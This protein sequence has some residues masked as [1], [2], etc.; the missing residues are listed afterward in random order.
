[1][2]PLAKML[3]PKPGKLPW[4]PRQSLH[5]LAA[6]RPRRPLAQ[7]RDQ[8]RAAAGHGPLARD[9]T[10]ALIEAALFLADEPL[11]ARKL[12][13]VTQIKSLEEVRRLVKRLQSFYEEEGTAFAVREI[14]G[15]YQLLSRTELHP[16]LL[17]LRPPGQDAKLSPPALETLAIV[18]YRQPVSRADIEAIRGVAC[19]EIL[20][21]LLERD[22]IRISGRDT[23]LGRPVLYGTTKAFLQLV[24]LNTLEELPAEGTSSS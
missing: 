14:A 4:Q 21:Q 10:L 9:A 16:W 12:G 19:G 6:Q 5:E 13:N 17:R 20:R 24:G 22:L 8:S 1:M 2:K 23:S 7:S 18:A 15:G 11:P 3:S